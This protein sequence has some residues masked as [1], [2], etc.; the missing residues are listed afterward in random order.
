MV[1]LAE[2]NTNVIDTFLALVAIVATTQD[3]VPRLNTDAFN[4]DLIIWATRQTLTVY[5]FLAFITADVFA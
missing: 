5:A 1:F 3:R 4:A 2:V